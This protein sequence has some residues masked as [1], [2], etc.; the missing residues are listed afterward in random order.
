MQP[1]SDGGAALHP[2]RPEH[3]ARLARDDVPGPR[4]QHR[5]SLQHPGPAL[6]ADGHRRSAR[7]VLAPAPLPDDARR[8]RLGAARRA[9]RVRRVLGRAQPEPVRAPH[10]AA[11]RAGARDRPRARRRSARHAAAPHGGDL[12]ALRVQPAEHAR[13][14]ADRRR[15]RGAARRLPG[16]R[17]HHD[18]AGP[19][20]RRAVPLRQRVSVSAGRRRGA[21][22]HP[23][24][25][26][27]RGSR[28][29]CRIWAGSASIPTNNLAATDGHIRV[30]IGRDYAD[31]PPTRGVFKG[32]S[33]VRSELAVGVTGRL[34]RSRSGGDATPFVPWMSRLRFSVAEAV[35]LTQ[36]IVGKIPKSVFKR[37]R[38]E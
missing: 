31:V 13:R 27:T 14:L 16:L 26:R 38:L 2:V 3:D 35:D 17:A 37:T 11:R 10:A 1:R 8:R 34:R 32:T 15:A 12:R 33:A 29:G 20:A 4:R 7:R 22:D 30:A 36:V 23:T 24:A 5:P 19:A 9:H 6:A 28:P 25:P 18:R 21:I